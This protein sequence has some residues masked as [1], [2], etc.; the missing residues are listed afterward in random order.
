MKF[1]LKP[2][3]FAIMPLLLAALFF[4]AFLNL[5]PKSKPIELLPLVREEERKEDVNAQDLPQL[6]GVEVSLF[7]QTNQLNWKLT[8]ENLIEE[9]DI[10]RLSVIKGE[11]F[12]ADGDRYL[13]QALSGKMG[14]EFT[15]LQLSPD[16]TI[17]GQDLTMQANEVNWDARSGDEITGKKMVVEREDLTVQAVEFR[18]MPEKGGL[19]VPG[20]SR[21]SFR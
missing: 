2:A 13:V 8:V 1:N 20:E 14:K 7:D 6:K 18:F 15:W 19:V 3:I 21:W 16:V 12:T 11:Y 17:T 5:K 10:Y 9:G 4:M